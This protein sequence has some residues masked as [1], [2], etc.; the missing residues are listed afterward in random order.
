MKSNNSGFTLIELI[1]VLAIIG[2]IVSLAA[3][4]ANLF[5]DFGV[6]NRQTAN[7]DVVH[8]AYPQASSE[9]EMKCVGGYKFMFSSSGQSVQVMD[10]GNAVKC[11][12]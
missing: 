6:S 7:S 8:S 4:V 11:E 12:K 2:I 1:I 10:A 5:L 9:P 3:P